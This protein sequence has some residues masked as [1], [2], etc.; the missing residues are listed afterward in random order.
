V[1]VAY[2]AKT[3][4]NNVCESHETAI[5]CPRDCKGDIKDNLCNYVS[6]GICDPD[7]TNMDKDCKKIN[8]N[9]VFMIAGAFALLIVF[10]IAGRSSK[11]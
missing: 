3:C 4:G 7:C 9:L 5:D 8:N 10:L 2:L 1:D 11:K 6:D